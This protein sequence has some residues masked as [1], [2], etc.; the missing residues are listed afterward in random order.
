MKRVIGLIVVVLISLVPVFSFAGDAAQLLQAV[1][2]G[3]EGTVAME[4]ASGASPEGMLT[5]V[6]RASPTIAAILRARSLELM[7]L[8][9]MVRG[10]LDC[11]RLLAAA[12]VQDLCTFCEQLTLGADPDALGRWLEPY[13]SPAFA[14][15]VGATPLMIARDIG[16]NSTDV[17]ALLDAA[18]CGDCVKVAL[19][20]AAGADP[21]ARDAATGMKPFQFAL[22]NGHLAAA[23]ILV[24]SEAGLLFTRFQ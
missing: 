9:S 23:D 18:S 24:T 2:L 6:F 3:D 20:L 22:A 1:S 17:A 10:P 19:L 4:L 14:A 16:V 15:R 5:T 8:P 12:K 7:S 13:L 21:S 11:S